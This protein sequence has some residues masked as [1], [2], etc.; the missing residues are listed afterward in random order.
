MFDPEVG[1]FSSDVLRQDDV[2]EGQVGV[3]TDEALLRD[4]IPTHQ[5]HEAYSAEDTWYPLW[6]RLVLALARWAAIG[7]P[8]YIQAL[9]KYGAYVA[10]LNI[11]APFFVWSPPIVGE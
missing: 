4:D 8:T 1:L 11:P 9:I 6:F 7:A 3:I 5:E 2:E 10:M